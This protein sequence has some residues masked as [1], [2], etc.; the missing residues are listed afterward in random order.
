MRVWRV[1]GRVM[2]SE[3]FA[4][5]AVTRH[6]LDFSRTESDIRL[7][8]LANRLKWRRASV[9]TVLALIFWSGLHLSSQNGEVRL[10]P[11]I[12]QANDIRYAYDELGRLVQAT[13]ATAGQS[14]QYT[15]DAVGNITSQIAVSLSI[16][17]V[18]YFS[19]QQGPAGATITISG[20]G[21]SATSSNNSVT[22]NGVAAVVQTATQTQLAVVVPTAATSGP[23]T[24]QVGASSVTTVAS[25]TVTPSG[26]GPT[27]TSLFPTIGSVGSVV[28]IVGTNFD[29]LPGNDSVVFDSTLATTSAS[30]LTTI[31]TS[32]PPSAGSGKVQVTTPRGVAISPMDF[33]VVPA[34]YAATSI[35]GTGRLP[36]DGSSTNLSLP[37]ASKINV[38]LFDASAG[39][40]LTIGITSLSFTTV[41]LKVYEPHGT[42]LVSGAVTG[43][44]QGLQLPKLPRSGT[45]T[46]VVDAGTQ[47][48][49]IGLSIVRPF[50]ATLTLNGAAT[51]VTLSPPGRRALLTFTGVQGT[52]ANVNLSAV[53]LSAGTVSILAPN[54]AVLDSATFGVSGT[55]LQPQLPL[56]GLYTVLV[57]PT[58]SVGGALTVTLTTSLTPTLT[59]NHNVGVSLPNT[60]PVNV[61]FDAVSG[62]YLSL[63][64]S[65][66]GDGV[67][68]ATVKVLKPDGSTLTTGTFTGSTC[69]G[70]GL[71]CTGYYGSTVLNLGAMPTGG[72]YT[73]VVQQVGSGSGTITLTL[74]TPV[75]AALT[76]G[77]QSSVTASLAGQAMQL[78]FTAAAGQYVSLGASE[79][80]DQISG[81][82]LTILNPDGSVLTNGSFTPAWCGGLGCASYS[83][84]GVTNLGPLSMS[85]T[86]TVLV[87]QS[88]GGT[89]TLTFVA[90]NPVAQTLS[91]GTPSSVR[92]GLLGQ[93]M[94]LTFAGAPGQYLGLG[95]IE[96]QYDWISS[97]TIT[98][99]NPDGTLLT[100]G[101]FSPTYCGGVGCLGYSGSAVVNLGPLPRVGTYTVLIQ[102]TIPSPSVGTTGT[103][104][105]TV[106]LS[107]PVSN[108][109]TAGSTSS[110]QLTLSG[111]PVLASFTGS[112]G[113]YFSLGISEAAF[114]NISGATVGVLNPDGTLL[115]TGTFTPTFCGGFGCNGY[116]GTGVVNIGPLQ[117]SGTY[118]VLVQQTGAGS[119]SLTLVLSTPV[120]AAL[121]VGTPTGPSAPLVGQAMQVTF[122]GAAGQYFALGISEN[123][124]QI[125]GA[126]ATALKPDG[127]TLATGSF[128][129]TYCAG[130]GCNNYSGTG[131]LNMGPLPVSGTY[132]VLIQQT[133][134]GYGSL[135]LTLSNPATGTLTAGTP[136]TI[137]ASLLGQGIQVTFAGA[138]GASV[139]MHVQENYGSYIPTAKISLFNPDGTPLAS[140]MLNAAT[141]SGCNGYAGSADVYPDVLTQT[142]TY[143]LLAQQAV[144]S[145]G[146][147]TVSG[148]G[149]QSFTSTSTSLSTS[150]LG[151]TATYTFVATAGQN[152]SIGVSNLTLTPTSPNWSYLYV[153]NPDG[154]LLGDINCGALPTYPGCDLT[155]TNLPQSGTYTVKV[156][157]P[158]QQTMTFTLGLSQD[159]GGAL[160]P[161]TTPTNLSLPITG[162][163]GLYSFTATAGQSFAL[164][165]GSISTT[166]ANQAV[167]ATIYNSTGTVIGSGS[168]TAN[169]TINLLGLAAGTYSAVIVP[170]YGATA[171]MQVTLAPGLT[172]A[173][174]DGSAVSETAGVPGQIGYFSFVGTAGQNLSIGISNLTLTPT[175]PN[176]NYLYVY[177]P[178]GTL[179]GYSY[180]GALPTYPGCDLTM[181]NLP[182][183]GTY[184]VKVVP[185]GQQT[186]SFT[187]GLSQDA[188]GAL[189]PSTTPTSL[190]LPIVGENGFYSFTASAGQSLALYVGSISTT[191]A[192]QTVTATVYNSAGTVVGNSSG[193]TNLTVNLL[194]L[195][196]DTYTV[197]VVPA[198]GAIGTMQVTLAPGLAGALTVGNA[199]SEAASV[200][201]QIGY[202]SFVGTAGQNLSI[203]IS[204]L[205]L[206]PTSPNWNYLYVY[207]PDGTLLGYSYCGALPTYPGCDLTM[208]NLPQSGTYT[209]KVVPP[210]QQ[211]MSF[212]LGLSQD[213]GG[214]LSPSTTPTSLSLPIVG[215]NG[216]YSFTASAGQSLALYIGSIST[217][218]ANQTVTATVYNSAGTVVGS[219]SGMTN[220]TVNLLGLPSADTYTVVVV[221]TY[222]AIS[223]MQVTLAPGLGGAL[224]AGNAVSEVA[225]VPGEDGYFTFVGTAG[226]NL[227]I[228]IS[229]LT[230]TPTSPNWSYLYVYNPDGTLLGYSYCGALPTY[231]GCD[232]TMTNL[233]QSGTYTVKVVPPG[234]QTMSFTLGLSQDA[235]GALTP[236][237]TPTSL[238]LPIVGENGF[239]SFTASAGQSLALYIGSISTTPANQT[240]TA[241]VYNSAGT[242]VGSAS[243]TTNFTINLLGLAAGTYTAV[244]VPA[245]GAIS[246][247]Q[248]TLAPGLAGALSAGNAVSEVASVPGEDGNFTFVATAG[249]N[250]SIGISNLT[251]TP[252]SSNWSYLYVYKP[253]GTLLGY[254]Y[255]GALPTYP[256]CDL[257]MTNLPQSGTYTVKVVP[258]G[259]QTMSF[260]LGLSQDAGG[261]LTPSTTPTSLSLP[262]VGEN[263]FYSFTASA[264]QSL[265]LY[266]GS[267]STTP[268]NQ[269][270]T[271]TVYNSAGTVV[272]SGSGTTNFTIN[273][274]GLAAG[275]YTAVIVPAYG[276]TATMQVTLAPGVTATLP[277][278]GSS[279]ILAANVPGQQIGNLSFS[280]SSGQS[281][282]LALS[283]LT[284]APTSGSWNYAY[285]YKP[286]GTALTNLNCGSVPTYPGCE[287]TLTNLPQ[288]G[289][290]TVKVVPPG[291]Q[292]LSLTSN[293]STNL[294][295]SLS[296]GTSASVNLTEVG[297]SESLSFTATA[298]ETVALAVS[299]VTTTPA[300]TSVNI[301]VYNASGSQVASA[302]TA[303][304][305]TLNMT[306]LAAGTYQVLISPAY[307]ATSAMQVVYH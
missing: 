172:G 62:Q 272:G 147:L 64:I 156:V 87:Q 118:S 230:L 305:T 222:G 233:P 44:G 14:V 249:Q 60:T 282:S 97:A 10:S 57:D 40:L 284:L 98:V 157:P 58:G 17:S 127:S 27:I 206:T 81:V 19:P 159:A 85:G 183:S 15:Y 238:S 92:A 192:N 236:S 181:T 197:V 32:V 72:T 179:L 289:T 105:L 114:G 109:L 219:G 248:V 143:T 213:A 36:T 191:P 47:I 43:V 158:G 50:Q 218:P 101:V 254:S 297:Q 268:A 228:G 202:F 107:A 83:G 4:E 84:T 186:M 190:S 161:S 227:S 209:V 279:T 63:T 178:D 140:G 205:T 145:T 5:T 55:A 128:A 20:T 96:G 160:P 216:F 144:A 69:N 39:D 271:A 195:A 79:G 256:G 86:Y 45:Y 194:G 95:V 302:S 301:Q 74:S 264:G 91:V 106:A 232:L 130:T 176:W 30:T 104:T 170:A 37:T 166:P 142:G 133:S 243:G 251:L 35:G 207:N 12:A 38:E 182:Q 303:T 260:T 149:I 175:S 217:T 53:S 224:S 286:D 116:Y 110:E 42:L 28:T 26:T 77:T 93:A 113:Q 150:T 199:V 270:V 293:L 122:T 269:T 165:V 61:P 54:G 129:P 88:V 49:I 75:T 273:L 155:M 201:G 250:L 231:P 90:S 229:N 80:S 1:Y 131:L 125:A 6:R 257:T 215:E 295:G 265:A 274:F 241:T 245:Y 220:L 304:G 139:D 188:G 212:T 154:T 185:P 11:S 2:D 235:G 167:T 280:A 76:L 247:M 262:I 94:Q 291:Q 126:T 171:T 151:Q 164:Y 23:I 70:S 29:P 137:G 99:L 300:N 138:A 9:T 180:C 306:N 283:N 153:Y 134:G 121:T 115:T 225:S 25:F 259:Q 24:V 287:L 296:L 292:Q 136:L 204:N 226:Q 184:T 258:P 34:G 73:V 246:T 288:S 7:V 208:T 276:A 13:D 123:T 148:N 111:Q 253:D 294:S 56:N 120:A 78:T 102:Q 59:V 117:Q 211:T 82:S 263:G 89:G 18:S 124:D 162:E 16:L 244:I 146:S 252:T 275:T 221:P 31:A 8:P 33:V 141:C 169:L 68:S 41:T 135:T 239:Y 177:N 71:G 119:G 132:S 46:V 66:G 266:V 193:T 240:V 168:G 65:E 277:S 48:G 21:F 298:G 200:P 187:L 223:T 174:T 163:N 198:Y 52:Y 299:G 234:Q 103:G 278:D 255:C 267:I 237:T 100:T 290:Y 307:P 214:A 51:P 261:A 152:L 203:G 3:A 242:V 67:A 22:F 108:P 173:L 210:G 281:L 285:V 189:T 196:A 112:A